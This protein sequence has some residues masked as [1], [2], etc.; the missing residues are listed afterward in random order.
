MNILQNKEYFSYLDVKGWIWLPNEK[1]LCHLKLH[2]ICKTS[3]NIKQGIFKWTKM[4][5]SKYTCQMYNICNS[6]WLSWLLALCADKHVCTFS[7]LIYINDKKVCIPNK[8]YICGH[9]CKRKSMATKW[10]IPV[11]IISHYIGI[12]K[13]QLTLKQGIFKWS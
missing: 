9:R 5:M 11:A 12:Y 7:K 1:Y 4:W 3:I 8:Q 2:T 10:K 6:P 13:N